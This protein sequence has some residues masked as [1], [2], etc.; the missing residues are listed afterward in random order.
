MMKKRT[1]R[2]HVVMA[3]IATVAWVTMIFPAAAHHGGAL[4]WNFDESVG[5]VTGI[6]TK[7]GFR[8]PHVQVFVDIPG[9][10]GEAQKFVFI[11]RWTP[12]ILTKHGWTRSSIKPGDKVTVTYIPHISNPTAGA[13]SRLEVNGELLETNFD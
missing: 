10:N 11:T 6:A 7:F 13:I 12:T 5:P 8:F 2:T 4:E 1:I 9:E 3:A